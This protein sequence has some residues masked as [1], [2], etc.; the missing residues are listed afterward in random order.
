M[1][2]LP[3][4]RFR[5][6]VGWGAFLLTG[7]VVVNA[8]GPSPGGESA[9]A[10]VT[11]TIPVPAPT[12]TPATAP[13]ATVIGGATTVPAIPTTVAGPPPRESRRV[14]AAVP[15]EKIRAT[16]LPLRSLG[17]TFG[18]VVAALAISGFVF[19][20]IRSRIPP[21]ANQKAARPSGPL[22]AGATRSAP[23]A[24][25]MPPPPATPLPPPT[26]EDAV[27]DT[28]IFE[29]PPNHH[30]SS[31]I[32]TPPTDEPAAV[33]M[34]EPLVTPEPVETE[35]VETEPVFGE[36]V[37]TLEPERDS[38]DESAESPDGR[39]SQVSSDKQ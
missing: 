1:P 37:E 23:V 34:P 39:E 25:Q 7:A 3:D 8:I 38:A 29:P 14:P 15:I 22:P 26:I 20:R 17:V 6:V 10:G 27:S 32:T 16:S 28:V 18:V 31:V 30:S 4:V 12:T 21:V 9:S 5:L 13:P 24:P 36:P 19:G 2:R 35:P 11:T 33:V